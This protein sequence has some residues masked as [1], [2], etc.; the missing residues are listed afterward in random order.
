MCK[1]KKTCFNILFMTNDSF[2]ILNSVIKSRSPNIAEIVF[3]LDFFFFFFFFL[4]RFLEAGGYENLTSFSV[5][6]LSI[7]TDIPEQTV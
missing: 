1:I 3:H 6:T 4:V 2:A 5:L 7:Q